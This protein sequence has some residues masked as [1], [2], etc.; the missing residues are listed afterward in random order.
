MILFKKKIPCLYLCIVFVLAFFIPRLISSS[1]YEA[2]EDELYSIDFNNKHLV[3]DFIFFPPDRAHPPLW[4][5]LMDKPTEIIG[6]KRGIFYYRLIQIVILFVFLAISLF[7]FYKKLSIRFLFIFFT[8]F[9]SNTYLVHLTTQNRMYAMVLG[10]ATLYSLYWYYL[11]KNNNDKSFK[12]FLFLGIIA[13]IGFL[14]NYSIIWLLPIWPIAYSITKKNKY[15]FLRLSCFFVTF[16]LLIS[17]FI[18][19]FIDQTTTF[20]DQAIGIFNFVT[21][22]RLFGEYFGILQKVSLNSNNIV[23]FPFLFLLA[24]L[25]FL[26]LKSRKKDYF[27][28]FLF[29]TL[30]MTV[31]FFIIAYIFRNRLFYTRVSIT[32]SIAFYVLIADSLSN[33]KHANKIIFAL[34]AIQLSQFIFYFLPIRQFAEY[35]TY[36]YR[37]NPLSYF[38][39]NKQFYKDS[40]IISIPSWEEFSLEYYLGDKVRVISLD[41]LDMEN[42]DN[43]KNC[44]T[45]YAISKKYLNNK[46]Q[47]LEFARIDEIGYKLKLISK[48]Q[49]LDL[50]LFKK[51][52]D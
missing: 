5:I 35:S 38:R 42:S 48:N 32:L 30:L 29:S 16:L 51:Y 28:G 12:H 13:A 8:L 36:Y 44:S 15:S 22:S 47:N 25:F 11:I 34:I 41:S 17:W 50:Y 10:I 4:Y 33:I 27:A 7:L 18:P 3:Q 39:R 2:M 49:N 21:V 45:I 20:D 52:N 37:R 14:T 31:L 1:Y 43:A 46:Y 40:C 24:V 26:Q 19:T 9:F 6:A 23:L